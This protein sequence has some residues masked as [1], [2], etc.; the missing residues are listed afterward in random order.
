MMK[1]T[2][3]SVLV[4]GSALCLLTGARAVRRSSGFPVERALRD[5]SIRTFDIDGIERKALI[6]RNAAWA[7][8]SAPVVFVF[9][10]HGGTAQDAARRFRIHELWPE[11][12]VAYMQGLTGVAGITDPQGVRTGWQ[13]NPAEVGDRDV[14]FFDAALAAIQK[15]F[16]TDPRRVYAF[17]HS[18]GARFVYV[19][20]NLRGKEFA[21]LSAA[22]APGTGLI[23]DA[24]PK[25]IFV[26]A[27]KSDAIVPFSGQSLSI[28]L[29]RKRLQADSSRST[30]DG[31]LRTEP[32]SDGN[33]L[34]TY[35]HPGGHMVPD[36]ALPLVI[37][38]FQRHQDRHLDLRRAALTSDA[39]GERRTHGS[40]AR[41]V[42]SA[43][44]T[45]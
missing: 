28:D 26:I 12:V 2:L 23:Q 9:H 24:V 36:E 7:G 1:R 13:K 38:F 42:A 37:K 18:N 29:T 25:S 40:P 15:E 43:Q 31:Y 5:S 35:I 14:R 4:I 16:R 19:L 45:R 22:S 21:A 17:G 3:L 44:S 8:D 34:V 30:T 41:P 11:A 39:V 10:G 20:W 27:G 32:A 33:E 6:Y